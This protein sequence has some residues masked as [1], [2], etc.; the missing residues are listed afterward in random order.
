MAL[1]LNFSSMLKAFGLLF[2]DFGGVRALC[3]NVHPSL[4]K[5]YF[6][7][8]WGVRVPYFL[9]LFSDPDSSC[10]FRRVFDNFGALLAA[11]RSLNELF[12]GACWL[13]FRAI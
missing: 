8:F 6:L 9:R 11:L 2:G 3:E 10:N 13:Q 5:S 1:W 12:W 7:R 4:A